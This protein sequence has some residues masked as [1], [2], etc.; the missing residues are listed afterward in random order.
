MIY[1]HDVDQYKDWS[2]QV[3]T[4]LKREQLWDIVQGEEK[5]PKAKNDDPTFMAWSKKNATAL[6]VIRNSCSSPITCAIEKIS[7]AKI[8]WDTLAGICALPKSKLHRYLYI[9]L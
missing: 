4:K 9:S 5:P 3:R 6:Q 8:A 2:L 1:L 7:L